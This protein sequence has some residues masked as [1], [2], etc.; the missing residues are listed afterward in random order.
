MQLFVDKFIVI[1]EIVTIVRGGDVNVKAVGAG[2][3][4]GLLGTLILG[5]YFAALCRSS[6]LTLR[7]TEHNIN[8]EGAYAK[9]RI[10]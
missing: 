1:G 5:G 9:N 4:R 10:V 3:L 7:R 2:A 6:E 8:F